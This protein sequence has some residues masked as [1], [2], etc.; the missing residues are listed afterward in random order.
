V[1]AL[2]ANARF[3]GLGPSAL[4]ARLS[5]E[6]IP[7]VLAATGMERLEQFINAE[8]AMGEARLETLRQVCQ[9]A[10]KIVAKLCA[11]VRE[12]NPPASRK[13]KAIQIEHELADSK[14]QALRQIGGVLWSMDAEPRGGQKCGEELFLKDLT[15]SNSFR[16]LFRSGDWRRDLHGQ[17]EVCLR[18]SIQSQIEDAVHL[19]DT[20]LRQV[21]TNF[22]EALC[23][24]FPN[25]P[26]PLRLP[27]F[28]PQQACPPGTHRA[29]AARL[30][31]SSAT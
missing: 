29:N 7:E 16:L 2:T 26:V 28:Q 4:A 11:R 15:L 8:V 27:E 21:W 12:P 3:R 14:E 25:G 24:S 20:D 6:D 13:A 9:Q 19:L 5:A 1:N 22:E 17:I 31:A 18:G 30:C 23:K 10:V